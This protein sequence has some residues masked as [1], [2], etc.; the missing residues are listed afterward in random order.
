MWQN[1]TPED[2]FDGVQYDTEYAPSAAQL[3]AD[4]I[5]RECWRGTCPQCGKR[6]AT[7][8]HVSWCDWQV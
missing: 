3:E 5:R 4:A 8:E 7:A 2:D 6:G 1:M